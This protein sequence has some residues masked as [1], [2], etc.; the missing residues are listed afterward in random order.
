MPFRSSK[1]PETIHNKKLFLNV[2]TIKCLIIKEYNYKKNHIRRYFA[3]S[4]PDFIIRIP[5][6]TSPKNT[7]NRHDNHEYPR[8]QRSHQMQYAYHYKRHTLKS[9]SKLIFSIQ[10]AYK[11]YV[12]SSITKRYK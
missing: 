12:N 8:H 10:I 7:R 1:I 11:T 6:Q 4:M 5:K 9:T 3:Q 2:L